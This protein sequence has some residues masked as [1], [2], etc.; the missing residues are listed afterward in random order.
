[1]FFIHVY[2]CACTFW[3]IQSIIIV[4]PVLPNHIINDEHQLHH[5]IIIWSY[6]LEFVLKVQWKITTFLSFLWCRTPLKSGDFCSGW[7]PPFASHVWRYLSA[8][9]VEKYRAGM[10]WSRAKEARQ[11]QD[12]SHLDKHCDKK[13]SCT[14]FHKQGKS[15]PQQFHPGSVEL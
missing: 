7:E 5:E 10:N 12:N 2:T 11:A 1:M 6:N 13:M 8:V 4:R 3:G 15:S 9:V 14:I